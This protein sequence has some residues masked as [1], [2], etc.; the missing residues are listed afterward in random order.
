M[1]RSS[2]PSVSD[3][4][5]EVLG[6]LAAGRSNAQ[7]A[8]VLHIS[9]RTVE[10]HVSSL[11][12]KLGAGDRH[13][14]AALAGPQASVPGGG[15]GQVAGLPRGR[16]TFVGRQPDRAAIVGALDDH[17]LVSVVGPGG[18]GKTRL[19]TV[20]AAE[21]AR[22]FAA[23][24]A[25]VDLVP[26]R[27]GLVAEAVASVLGVSELPDQ[28]VSGTIAGHL[29]TGRFLLMLDN[30]EHVVDEVGTL[31]GTLLDRCPH[32]VVLATSRERLGLPDERLVRLGPL[33]TDPDG[34]RLF[35]D[36]ARAGDPDLELDREVVADICDHLDGMPLAIEIAAA[37]ASSLGQD[38]LRAAISDHVRLVN[39]ARG[40]PPRHTSLN[41]VMD[42]SYD[43]LDDAERSMLRGLSVFAGSFDLAS[44]AWVTG[45]PDTAAAADL[46][47]RLVDSSLVVRAT[48]T[49]S[50]RWRLLETV[51]A[52]ADAKTRGAERSD[53]VAR[54]LRW[55]IGTAT[56][57][58]EALDGS[59]LTE[60]D[61]VVDDLREAFARSPAA[62][63]PAGREL[64]RKLAHL[65]FARGYLREARELYVAAAARAADDGQAFD[66][67]R[68][69]ADVAI[70]GSDV[71][72]GVD[73]LMLAAR[74]VG[75][76]GNDAA[77]AW[78]AAV[79]TQVRF[80]YEYR[81]AGAPDH[82]SELLEAARRE[83][84]PDD[85]V[86]TALIA[87][88]R[89][90]H[91]GGLRRTDPART[92]VAGAR[93]SGDPIV[94]LRALDVLSATLIEQGRLHDALEVAG[95]RLSLL[96]GLPRHRPAAATEIS[97][98]F[99]V[100]INL[101]VSTGE[102]AIAGEFLD[103]AEVEDPT[104]NPYIAIPRRIAVL[105]LTG[106]FAAAIDQGAELWDAWRRDGTDR[107]WL[108]PAFNL[109]AL[110][111]G[112][113]G[114]GQHGEWLERTSMVA[115]ADRVPTDW[116]TV[117]AAFV[118]ARIAL[119]TGDLTA[120]PQLVDSAFAA[121]PGWAH[122]SD[123]YARATGAE[124]AVAAGLAD[125][126]ER[127]RAAEPYAAENRWAAATLAR[128][129]GRLLGR[130]EDLEAAA[131]SYAEIGAEFERTSTL[132]LIPAR[133]A[134]PPKAP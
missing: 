64:A 93:A 53:L 131:T 22:G 18:M 5:A 123:G 51:R 86:V 133:S 61:A 28:E 32:L 45:A 11:L 47:G 84:D 33:P 56:R 103:R 26:V 24:A 59:W 101:A 102:L 58:E 3:R 94:T 112:L 100:A 46:L 74:R 79:E 89:A 43:L 121:P 50:T 92:A 99:Q 76:H 67:L 31:V 116:M 127:I 115:M 96:R 125:A 38:G 14:L 40:V 57:L 98:T 73:L 111:H 21:S 27:P 97:D 39:G 109:V 66:D 7:I 117:R 69:A 122:R 54:H 85:P 128:A 129:R 63:D 120:A 81:G 30:C 55:A 25:F 15:P 113:S 60:F 71:Q 10:N 19:A 1:D 119:H 95:D 108:A 91:E 90:W 12:R 37:R 88:A 134:V 35:L 49:G 80:G 87:T 48:T 68:D 104:S 72:A 75:D 106:R 2:L 77:A 6:H 52:F 17:R 124:L 114:D 105:A 42:W 44:V 4:E 36:R 23:G 130:W 65:T 41:T 126:E 62:P 70:A 107:R 110:A 13:E 9:V 16:S 132:Q 118:R 83:A 8:H 82:R 34:V 29:G 78:A 20:V